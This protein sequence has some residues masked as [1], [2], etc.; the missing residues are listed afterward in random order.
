MRCILFVIGFITLKTETQQAINFPLPLYRN[1][2]VYAET[3][4]SFG[5]F[6][7]HCDGSREKVFTFPNI[8]IFRGKVMCVD[9]NNHVV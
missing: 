1:F 5:K 4:P 3:A 6:S 2:R 7:L 8:N 9:V